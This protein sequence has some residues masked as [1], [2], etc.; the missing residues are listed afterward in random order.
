MRKT[1]AAALAAVL[2]ML[3]C[4]A[5]APAAQT[6]DPVGL[7]PQEQEQPLPAGQ[8]TPPARELEPEVVPA[9]EQTHVPG[10]DEVQDEPMTLAADIEE[11]VSYDIRVP[12][13]SL[14]QE[15]AAQRI[16]DGFAELA[17]GF[18]RYAQETVY[19]AAQ[20]KQTI[21]YLEGDYS[22]MLDGTALVVEYTLRERYACEEAAVES[23][24][25]YRFDVQT[26]ARIE[27]E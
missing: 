13:V 27:T 16:N 25:T 5:C 23:S 10:A 14:E 1:I 6:P 17:E 26:G 3:L 12:Q 11:I 9:P 19:K 24:R 15:D 22:I 18:V 7:P 8:Q 4:S 21:G 20:E 2:L